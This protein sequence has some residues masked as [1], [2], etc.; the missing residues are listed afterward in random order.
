MK[1][2]IGEW[3]SAFVNMKAPDWMVRRIMR[4]LSR[5]TTKLAGSY[6]AFGMHDVAS[7]LSAIAAEVREMAG[8]FPADGTNGNAPLLNQQ[9][10]RIETE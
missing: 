5:D 8:N 9:Q 6:R 3:W 4:K 10:N 7:E 1:E 2:R